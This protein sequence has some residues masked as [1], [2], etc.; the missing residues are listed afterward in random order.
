M[1][2]GVEGSWHA[3]GAVASTLLG[4]WRSTATFYFVILYTVLIKILWLPLS[5]RWCQWGGRSVESACCYEAGGNILNAA[6]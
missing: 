2:T 3:D 6:S 4:D 1:Y 5:S